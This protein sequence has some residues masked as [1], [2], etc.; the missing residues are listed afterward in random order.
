MLMNRKNID[1]SFLDAI[2]RDHRIFKR[3]THIAQAKVIS[4]VTLGVFTPAT[5][6]YI[7]VQKS[8][9]RKDLEER[10]KIDNRP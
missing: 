7:A 2:D 6:P 1:Q 5:L 3:E 8:R 4:I 9:L 10:E